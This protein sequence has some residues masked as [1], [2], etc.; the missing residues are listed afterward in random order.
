VRRQKND[1][2]G[3]AAICEAVR[4]PSM[5]FVPIKSEAQQAMLVIHRARDLL[6]RQRTSSVNALCGHLAEF[7]VVLPKGGQTGRKLPAMVL[8]GETFG[9]PKM[10][11]PVLRTAGAP[12]PGA[13]GG[14]HPAG[15]RAAPPSGRGPGRA[16]FANDPGHRPDYGDR[17]GGHR[18]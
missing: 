4:R 12:L 2:A 16:A 13:R 6:V 15:A 5:R 14:N 17:A 8:V 11:V 7:G 10:V 9:M 18:S 3:A 1:T